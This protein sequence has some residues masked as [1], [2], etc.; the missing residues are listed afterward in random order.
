MT[1]KTSSPSPVIWVFQEGKNDYAPAEKYGTVRF[2]TKSDLRSVDGQQN[3]EVYHDIRRFTTEYVPGLD[4]LVP[5]GNPMV[6]CQIMI[7]IGD[8][9]H[10]I[11]KW[12]GYRS[13]YIPFNIAKSNIYKQEKINATYYDA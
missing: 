8:G 6:I 13:E 9:P 12:D 2:I 11:L 3:A 1:I 4:Y 5:V 7:A 10:K